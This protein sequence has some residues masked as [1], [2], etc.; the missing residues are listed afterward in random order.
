MR[1]LQETLS[2]RMKA[3]KRVMC[4]RRSVF[5][6]P[7]G[8][9]SPLL[10]W[11]LEKAGY[12]LRRN[13]K[14]ASRKLEQDYER[15]CSLNLSR[16]EDLSNIF[17]NGLRLIFKQPANQHKNLAVAWLSV[18]RISLG[19]ESPNVMCSVRAREAFQLAAFPTLKLM[20]RKEQNPKLARLEKL[21]LGEFHKGDAAKGFKDAGIFK[22]LEIK[23]EPT[24]VESLL[25]PLATL[26]ESLT[27]SLFVGGSP[28]E[29]FLQVMDNL[30]AGFKAFLGY[31][32]AQKE[33]NAAAKEVFKAENPLPPK[34][35]KPKKIWK[36]RKYNPTMLQRKMIQAGK[37]EIRDNKLVMLSKAQ[38]PQQEDLSYLL[39]ASESPVQPRSIRSGPDSRRK[40][41]YLEGW[42]LL[43]NLAAI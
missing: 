30:D 18:M 12:P 37:A 4:V 36:P 3:V 9:S 40:R 15:H 10:W 35:E 29:L 21:G 2:A 41:N 7:D 20:D 43:R 17:W 33:V 39:E 24:D 26:L 13:D 34:P 42:N 32:I 5:H 1:K 31:I 22:L 38:E 27:G 23:D 6:M 19:N 14:N 16:E 8:F 28:K 11:E 25:A